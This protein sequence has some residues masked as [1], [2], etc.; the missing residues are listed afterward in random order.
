MNDVDLAVQV[1]FKEQEDKWKAKM[2]DI[3]HQHKKEIQK[4]DIIIYYIYIY[5]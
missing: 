4:V 5:I 1:R 2:G 3:D